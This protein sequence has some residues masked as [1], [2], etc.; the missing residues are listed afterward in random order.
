MQRKIN[1]FFLILIQ[2]NINFKLK[3]RN[4][5]STND[6]LKNDRQNLN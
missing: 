1:N 6:F 2:N 5:I 3:L 4:F